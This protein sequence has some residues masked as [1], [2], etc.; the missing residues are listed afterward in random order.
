MGG[1]IRGTSPLDQN[2]LIIH[3]TNNWTLRFQNLYTQIRKSTSETHVSHTFLYPSLP[4]NIPYMTS[5][6]WAPY[7]IP[8][9]KKPG[10]SS[11][12]T[13]MRATWP[14]SQ[15]CIFSMLHWFIWRSKFLLYSSGLCLGFSFCLDS[16]LYNILG[17]ALEPYPQCWKEK[18]NPTKAKSTKELGTPRLSPLLVFFGTGLFIAQNVLVLCPNPERTEMEPQEKKTEPIE[19]YWRKVKTP[20][21]TMQK[22]RPYAPKGAQG[23]K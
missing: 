19:G 12:T 1:W 17:L 20:N 2:C 13:S 18:G 3:S 22:G 6:S 15:W 8:S 7:P 16:S 21:K 9:A 11:G 14:E 10:S 5:T 23:V 4:F